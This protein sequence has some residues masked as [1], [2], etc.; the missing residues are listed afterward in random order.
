MHSTT[1]TTLQRAAPVIRRLRQP[2]S[3]PSGVAATSKADAEWSKSLLGFLTGRTD[4]P[5]ERRRSAIAAEVE[6]LF[7]EVQ[8]MPRGRR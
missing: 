3:E 7:R 2:P 6:E 1:A 5:V 4:R 8:R